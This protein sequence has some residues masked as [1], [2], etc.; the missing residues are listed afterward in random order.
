MPVLDGLAA[1]RAI[2]AREVAGMDG[3]LAKPITLD[4]LRAVLKTLPEG[5]G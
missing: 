1:A 4:T 2:R 3:F 5:D